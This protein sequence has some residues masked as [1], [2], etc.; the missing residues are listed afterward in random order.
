MVYASEE[1]TYVTI[2][3]TKTKMLTLFAKAMAKHS[4][5]PLDAPVIHTTLP[6][7]TSA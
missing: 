5:I 7:K 6:L 3:V 2:K 1:K 4:P